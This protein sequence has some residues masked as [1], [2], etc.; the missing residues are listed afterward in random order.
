MDD[1]PLSPFA[2]DV[3]WLSRYCKL[4]LHTGVG[5]VAQHGSVDHP[6]SRLAQR[7]RQSTGQV[8]TQHAELEFAASFLVP[9]AGNCLVFLR[10]PGNGRLS[11]DFGAGLTVAGDSPDGPFRLTCPQYH[12]KAASEIRE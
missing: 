10:W 5:K 2:D 12:I 1:I 11:R 6:L 3:A 7:M 4:P 9:P 8:D